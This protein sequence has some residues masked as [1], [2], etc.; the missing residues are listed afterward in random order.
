MLGIVLFAQGCPRNDKTVKALKA[1][2]GG[3]EA[4]RFFIQ[5]PSPCATAKGQWGR[6]TSGMPAAPRRTEDADGLL[7]CAP[8]GRQGVAGWQKAQGSWRS[9]F[10]LLRSSGQ[11]YYRCRYGVPEPRLRPGQASLWIRLP[12]W[13]LATTEGCPDGGSLRKCA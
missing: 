2:E 7:G 6:A 13:F 8:G 4:E 5:M 9:F 3:R 1:A 12:A 10:P 11:P